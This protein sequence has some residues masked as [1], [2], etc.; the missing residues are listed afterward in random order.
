MTIHKYTL[1]GEVSFTSPTY[2]QLSELHE[3]EKKIQALGGTACVD[4]YDLQEETEFS[5]LKFAKFAAKELSMP[6]AMI[7]HKIL[8]APTTREELL[9][10]WM[11]G[12]LM[13]A[14]GYK[15]YNKRM[16]REAGISEE[17]IP[18]EYPHNHPKRLA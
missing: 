7:D 11:N 10:K 4:K 14:S 6:V 1:T 5:P 3:I 8:F 12:P 16:A 15:I 2:K 17:L 9:N 13:S 18:V